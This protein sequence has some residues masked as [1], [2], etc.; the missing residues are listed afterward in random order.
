MTMCC[1]T[2]IYIYSAFV[3][4]ETKE[5]AEDADKESIT[6]KKSASQTSLNKKEMRSDHTQTENR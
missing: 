3:A 4:S 1:L 5:L 6:S 2:T